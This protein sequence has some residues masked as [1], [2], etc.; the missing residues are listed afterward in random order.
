MPHRRE[1]LIQIHGVTGRGAPFTAGVVVQN[2]Y[3]RQAAPILKYMVGW[4]EARVWDYAVRKMWE[5]HEV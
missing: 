3:V 2:G 1:H 4:P 5:A